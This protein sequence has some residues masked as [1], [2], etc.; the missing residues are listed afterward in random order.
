MTNRDLH[1]SARPEAASRLWVPLTLFA[2]L[3]LADQWLKWW[4]EANLQF[5]QPV[6]VLIPG[7]LGLTLT[8]N[9]GAAWSL[10]SGAALPLA[11]GRLLVG[12]GILVYLV[13]R[14]QPPVLAVSLGMIAAGAVGNA[15]DGLRA[16]KVTD[17]LSSPALDAVTRTIHGQPFPIF[18][19]ADSAVVVG[20]LLLLI[21]SVL[22]GQAGGVKN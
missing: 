13:R 5:G 8:Y 11:L 17:M 12:L 9:T 6:D 7:L 21:S 16:G 19:I 3:L 22:P 20:V 10:L 1:A 2:V 18:N 14:P 4:S 15:I